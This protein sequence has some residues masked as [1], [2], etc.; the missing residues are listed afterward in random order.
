ML[1]FY[2]KTVLKIF[3]EISEKNNVE[4]NAIKMKV[5]YSAL[6]EQTRKLENLGLLEIKKVGRENRIKFTERGKKLV[7]L[8]KEI[9]A[10]LDEKEGNGCS[11]ERKKGK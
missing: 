7:I 9:N 4:R 11:G 1:K 3:T 6:Y 2:F 5:S 10:I 8:F